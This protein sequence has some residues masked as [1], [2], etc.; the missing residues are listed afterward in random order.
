LNNYGA[1][2]KSHSTLPAGHVPD[3]AI[4]CLHGFGAGADQFENIFEMALRTHRNLATKR[5]LIVCPQ[6]EEIGGAPA[7]FPLDPMKWMMQFAQ[8]EA[9]IARLI[10][11]VPPGMVEGRAKILACCKAVADLCGFNDFGRVIISGFSQVHRVNFIAC[12]DAD[13]S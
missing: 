2:P 12:G 11:D 13:S 3:V 5:L 4:V 1:K 8:G 10:R 7:W 9:G 6:A